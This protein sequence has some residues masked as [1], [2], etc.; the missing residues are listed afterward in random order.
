MIISQVKIRF[1]RSIEEEIN[2]WGEFT[3][4]TSNEWEMGN[5]KIDYALYFYSYDRINNALYLRS[6]DPKK[7]V[8]GRL[9]MCMFNEDDKELIEQTVK[10]TFNA[11]P[12]CIKYGI[13]AN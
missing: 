2:C 9:D 10:D 3:S 8:C 1:D 5:E 12:L 7:Y 4:E 13:Y 6:A 11:T